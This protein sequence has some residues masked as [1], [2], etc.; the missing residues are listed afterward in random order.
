MIR[1]ILLAAVCWWLFGCASDPFA[2]MPAECWD[3][4]E[5]EGGER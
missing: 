3:I 2:T 5:C 1:L 4:Q